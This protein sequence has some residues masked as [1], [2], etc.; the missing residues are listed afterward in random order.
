MLRVRIQS[1]L[2]WNHR[3]I[4]ANELIIANRKTAGA[5][6]GCLK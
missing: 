2:L 1:V 6:A 5:C 3:I 4:E